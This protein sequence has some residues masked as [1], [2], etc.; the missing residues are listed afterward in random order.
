MVKVVVQNSGKKTRVLHLLSCFL[1][2]PS[3]SPYIDQKTP[4]MKSHSYIW[5]ICRKCVGWPLLC[6]SSI[7]LT[8]ILL[9]AHITQLNFSWASFYSNGEIWNLSIAALNIQIYVIC[10]LS[11]VSVIFWCLDQFSL[12]ILLNLCM[13]FLIATFIRTVRYII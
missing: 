7:T 11:Q 1:L 9:I 3:Y 6:I 4:F 12:I 8:R 2:L 5:E 10:I 13:Y